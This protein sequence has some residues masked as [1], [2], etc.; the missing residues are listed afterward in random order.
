MI[1]M[2][3]RKTKKKKILIG[4]LITGI[5]LG[6]LVGLY[7]RLLL[8]SSFSFFYYIITTFIIL[9]FLWT[10]YRRPTFVELLAYAISVYVLFQYAWDYAVGDRGSSRWLLFINAIVLLILNIL[11]GRVK[12]VG[13][14]ATARRAIGLD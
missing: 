9:F 8:P 1:N 6:S 7:L 3:T 13:A 14:K 5:G 11:T 12:F 4:S 10:A 2:I